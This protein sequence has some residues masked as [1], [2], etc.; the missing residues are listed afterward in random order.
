MTG[1]LAHYR[2]QAEAPTAVPR[3]EVSSA[4]AFAQLTGVTTIAFQTTE[5]RPVPQVYRQ[6]SGMDG[7]LTIHP[8]Q[9]YVLIAEACSLLVTLGVS[10]R[11]DSDEVPLDTYIA[12]AHFGQFTFLDSLG[13]TLGGARIG[14]FTRDVCQ[15]NLA[16]EFSFFGGTAS[17]VATFGTG[18]GYFDWKVRQ[19]WQTGNAAVNWDFS[20]VLLDLGTTREWPL[21]GSG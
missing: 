14:P 15:V 3:A 12:A 8:S 4:P 18:G 20:F 10:W 21:V 9:R 7:L 11:R 17:L 19:G 1:D 6:S 16:D 5:S 13:A 2:I